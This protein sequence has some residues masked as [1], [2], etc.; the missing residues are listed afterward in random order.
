MNVSRGKK[1]IGGNRRENGVEWMNVSRGK[2]RSGVHEWY[3]REKRHKGGKGEKGNQRHNVI[4]QIMSATMM[5]K[6]VDDIT[7]NSL[8]T[9]T[10]IEMRNETNNIMACIFWWAFA[11]LVSCRKCII[12]KSSKKFV[13]QIDSKEKSNGTNPPENKFKRETVC[14]EPVARR[15][16]R[17]AEEPVA[18]RSWIINET[19]IVFEGRLLPKSICRCR[20][21]QLQRHRKCRRHLRQPE[22]E[23]VVRNS[24]EFVFPQ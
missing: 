20:R 11:L 19:H 14:E 15:S 5:S 21:V 6:M 24:I 16:W 7:T 12:P 23:R 4:T 3:G 8:L 1:R 9:Y 17:S 2:K 22:E 18:R 10:D 13:Q